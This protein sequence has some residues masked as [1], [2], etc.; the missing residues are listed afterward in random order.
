MADLL[1]KFKVTDPHF[2]AGT[3]Q[4]RRDTGKLSNKGEGKARTVSS[5]RLH[6]CLYPSPKAPMAGLPRASAVPLHLQGNRATYRMVLAVMEGARLRRP[7]TRFRKYVQSRHRAGH[8]AQG[9]L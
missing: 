9:T 7:L 8:T 3:P 2:R 5:K 6:R 1:P 4:E